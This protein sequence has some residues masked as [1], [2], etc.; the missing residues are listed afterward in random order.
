MKQDLFRLFLF[1]SWNQKQK[2]LVCLDVSNLYQNNQNKQNCFET[3]RKNSKLSEKYQNMLPN[4][5]FR[6]V[7]CLFQFIQSIESFCYRKEAKQLKQT[8]LKQTE[9]PKLAVLV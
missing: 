2:F 8:V 5:L 7:F 3:N 9:T 1:V 4:K 6:L